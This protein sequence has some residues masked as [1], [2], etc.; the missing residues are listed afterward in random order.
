[1]RG[2]IEN[3]VPEEMVE[4]SCSTNVSN[5]MQKKQ[6]GDCISL[7]PFGLAT[8]KL[9]GGL[10]M[11]HGTTDSE[12]MSTLYSAAHSWLKQLG[13]EHHDFDFFTTH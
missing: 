11:N 13:V 4:N 5:V 8:Y 2:S 7:S 6:G 1:M 12:L 10:W 3:I 9:Q